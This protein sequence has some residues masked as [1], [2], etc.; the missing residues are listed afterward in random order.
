MIAEP[1]GADEA[2]LLAAVERLKGEFRPDFVYLFGSRARGTDGPNSDYDILVVVP[3]SDVPGHW[4]DR[5]ALRALRGLAAPLDVVVMTREQFDRGR[6]VPTSL[7]S[8][9]SREG[10]LLHAA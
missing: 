4:L 1:R 8:I 9:V 5:A 10:R 3:G 6:A 7:P 2:I